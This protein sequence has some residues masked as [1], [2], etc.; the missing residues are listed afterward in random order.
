MRQFE[1]LEPDEQAAE[2]ATM[3]E[4]MTPEAASQ[5]GLKASGQARRIL[6]TILAGVPERPR[7]A[8]SIVAI[9]ILGG[10]SAAALGLGAATVFAGF[11]SSPF[12]GFAGAALGVLGGLLAPG[13]FF[14]NRRK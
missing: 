2:L 13:P 7:N 5:V 8:A 14:R 6:F 12:F 4:K 9:A 10:L 1:N 11:E 3:L